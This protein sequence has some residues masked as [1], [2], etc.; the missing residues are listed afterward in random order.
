V[1]KKP[2]KQFFLVSIGIILACIVISAIIYSELTAKK[3]IQ[4]LRSAAGVARTS[5]KSLEDSLDSPLLN[6]PSSIVESP[7]ANAQK[8]KTAIATYK[9]KIDTLADKSNTLPQLKYADHVG[10]FAVAKTLQGRSHH[11][12]NQT[13][14]TL[15]RYKETV[16]F[17]EIYAQ[18]LEKSTKTME[19]FNAIVDF[20]EYAGRSDYFRQLAAAIR[21][22]ADT[23]TNTPTPAE[24]LPIKESSVKTLLQLA[25]QLNDLANGMDVAIDDTIY[26][27][28]HSIESTNEQLNTLVDKTYSETTGQLRVISDIYD[29]NEK[30]DLI[31][32]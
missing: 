29:I 20:N 25:A 1:L 8:L 26:G 6:D 9:A 22:E 30:F 13:N 32:Q 3:Y 16:T 11:I 21:N 24:L 28:A 15:E 7:A 2:S 31:L 17:L 19:K 12:V 14:D 5:V 10:T 23:L 27:S 4:E 18:S